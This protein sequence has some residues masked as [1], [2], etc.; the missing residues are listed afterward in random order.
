MAP[1]DE[2]PAPRTTPDNNSAVAAG[3][4]PRPHAVP[5]FP[6]RAARNSRATPVRD[7]MNRMA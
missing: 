2:H 6:P 1:R 4:S 7:R 3:S 5:G